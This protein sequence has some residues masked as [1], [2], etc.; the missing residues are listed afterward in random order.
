[1][2]IATGMDVHASDGN[3]EKEY[4][5]YFGK[6]RFEGGFKES[7]F[8]LVCLLAKV[9]C[10]VRII[11]TRR[12]LMFLFLPSKEKIKV[13]ILFRKRFTLKDVG[14]GP[15]ALVQRMPQ[16]SSFCFPIDRSSRFILCPGVTFYLK[17]VPSACFPS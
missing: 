2:I 8:D 9:T 14:W 4:S 15:P 7:R 3:Q 16:T 1:M 10:S 17:Y 12:L 6:P 13:R 11:K 5:N